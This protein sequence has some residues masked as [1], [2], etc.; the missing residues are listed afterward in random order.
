MIAGL[1]SVAKCRGGEGD[2]I[3]GLVTLLY[4]VMMA[5][6]ANA[7]AR[8]SAPT[9]QWEASVMLTYLWETSKQE[10]SEGCVW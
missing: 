10:A 6:E 4:S 8:P 9:L 5:S 7:G 1:S 2:S 3:A